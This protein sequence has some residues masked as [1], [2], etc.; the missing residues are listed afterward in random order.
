MHD[1][2][3]KWKELEVVV[4]LTRHL[5]RV[6]GYSFGL[7]LVLCMITQLTGC[8]PLAKVYSRSWEVGP[9]GGVR[10]RCFPA[11]VYAMAL[12]SSDAEALLVARQVAVTG[13]LS[14]E[15][16]V[17]RVGDI[18]QKAEGAA[19]VGSDLYFRK[20]GSMG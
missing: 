12:P 20:A 8:R 15:G 4:T 2:C 10:R 3:A 17:L 13:E 11:R 16:S 19:R 9:E 18:R 1:L 14:L 7:L 5:G 6:S